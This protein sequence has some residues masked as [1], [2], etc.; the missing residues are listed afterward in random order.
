MF[1]VVVTHPT[2]DIT[3]PVC[4]KNITFQPFLEK[5]RKVLLMAVESDDS[6]DILKAII[7]ILTN[8]SLTKID[9]DEL[10]TVDVEYFFVHLRAKSMGEIT[11]LNFRC[12]NLVAEKPCNNVMHVDVDI[13]TIEVSELKKDM[14]VKFTPTL[15]VKMKYP[16]FKM[17]D[18]FGTSQ[19]RDIL[20]EVIAG[21]IDCVINGEV[22][23]YAKDYK[24]EEMI[25]FV[26]SLTTTQ[27][28]QLQTFVEKLPVL[29]KTIKHTCPK[30]KFNHTIV[31]SGY[32]SFFV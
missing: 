30:C 10:T 15:V 3:L 5:E 20:Y 21:S 27:F 18:H 22:I 13:T 23:Y 1:P 31:L 11:T 26:L 12:D 25:D 6:K 9:I 16:S 19:T 14:L 29:S 7:Q 24:Q 8:C 28:T 4:K 17:I 2:Y 32:Q